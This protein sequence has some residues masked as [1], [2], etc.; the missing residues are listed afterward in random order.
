MSSHETSLKRIVLFIF[1]GAFLLRVFHLNLPILEAYNN[2]TRQ[3]V[4]GMIA[5]NYY[6]HGFC[7]WMPE[8]DQGAGPYLFNAEMPIGPYLTAVLYWLLGGVHEWAARLVSVCFSMAMLWFLYAFVKKVYGKAQAAIA[9]GFAAVSPLCLAFS[10]ALQPDI[11]MLAGS[12]GGLYYFYRYFEE[13]KSRHFIFSVLLTTLA[14]ASKAYALYLFLPLIAIA[15]CA[16][17]RRLLQD[18]KNYFYAFIVLLTLFWYGFMWVQGKTQHLY[19][20]TIRYDRGIAYQSFLE[21]FSAGNI[22]IFLKI[23]LIHILTPA[24]AILFFIGFVRRSTK[25][26]DLIFYAWFGAVFLF[27]LVTW[28]IVLRNPYYELPLVLPAAVFVGR[29]AMVILALKDGPF[30]RCR[31]ILIACLVV[32]AIPSLLYFYRGLYSLPPERNAILAAGKAA[33]AKTSPDELLIAS[34]EGGP[35]LL[36]Y[37]DRKGWELDLSGSA[38]DPVDKLEALRNRGASAFVTIKKNLEHATASFEA[39]LRSHYSI[40]EENEDYILFHVKAGAA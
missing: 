9:T 12:A 15:W 33:Q 38:G 32:I 29:G 28:R 3:A 13:K 14:V 25:K 17:K 27:L 18:P 2:L 40:L 23:F 36:Y 30:G 5:R 20:D 19:Y 39:Y 21:L 35:A 6:R 22:G 26:E 31:G 34:Y 10:R 11:L 1:S 37:C 24:G 7:F 4:S 8:L 16:Q